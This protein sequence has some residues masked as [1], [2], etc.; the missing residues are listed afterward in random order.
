MSG[1]RSR[2]RSSRSVRPSPRCSCACARRSAWWLR[3]QPTARRPTRGPR[4]CPRAPSETRRTSAASSPTCCP[5]WTGSPTGSTPTTCGRSWSRSSWSCPQRRRTRTTR[6]AARRAPAV[7]AGRR[8]AGAAAAGRRAARSRQ[9]C[10]S[11]STTSSASCRA[12]VP[13]PPRWG[14]SAATWATARS[15]GSRGYSPSGRSRTT[16]RGSCSS[17]ARWRAR[18]RCSTRTP[19]RR[20]RS[21]RAATTPR[22]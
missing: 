5:R 6:R 21:P 3:S 19:S 20:S 15:A 7:V 17:R 11:S 18:A 4:R 10:R 16:R 2:A 8:A 13:T 9:R 14:A 22:S 1:R 12:K